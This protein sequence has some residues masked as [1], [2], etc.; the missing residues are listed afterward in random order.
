MQ[1]KLDIIDEEKEKGM[2][3]KG[4]VKEMLERM[5]RQD[6]STL[7][8]TNSKETLRKKLDIEKYIEKERDMIR[9]EKE[10]DS[11][12]NKEWTNNSPRNNDS[13]KEKIDERPSIRIVLSITMPPFLLLF[14][15]LSIEFKVFILSS[16]SKKLSFFLSTLVFI[17]NFL[18]TM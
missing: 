12:V 14:S 17:M 4:I 1:E 6:N 8:L 5:E 11:L 3:K 18:C 9:K 2:L 15:C 16:R 10:N 13:L 7:K